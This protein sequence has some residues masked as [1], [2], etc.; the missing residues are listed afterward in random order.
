LIPA[1]GFSDSAQSNTRTPSRANS[2]TV[3]TTWDG[4]VLLSTAARG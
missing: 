1:A 4:L 2:A 3:F